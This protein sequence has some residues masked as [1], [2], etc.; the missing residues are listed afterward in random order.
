ME[1]KNIKATNQT[2]VRHSSPNPSPSTNIYAGARF[3]QFPRIFPE[4]IG[5]N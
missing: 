5:P 4:L 1:I 3:P 2:R